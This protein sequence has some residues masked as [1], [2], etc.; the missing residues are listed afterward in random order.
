MLLLFWTP[1][2]ASGPDTAAEL[3]LV[4]SDIAQT[5]LFGSPVAGA[6]DVDGDGFDDLVVGVWAQ[7]N[8]CNGDG[9]AYLFHGSSEGIDPASEAKILSDDLDCGD[10]Y[11]WSVFG[12]VD[13]DQDGFDEVVVGAS[14]E[15]ADE[16]NAS[17]SAYVFHGAPEGLADP[18]K[19]MPQTSVSAGNFGKAIGGG[20]LNGD[21]FDDL[22]IGAVSHGAEGTVTGATYVYLGGPAGLDRGTETLLVPSDL[23]EDIDFGRAVVAEDVDGDGYADL[24]LGS[25]D[26]GWAEDAGAVYIYSGG[27]EGPSAASEWKLLA[28]DAVEEQRFGAAIAVGD[29]DADG[30]VELVVGAP[31]DDDDRG[32]V[33]VYAGTSSGPDTD[34]EEVLRLEDA[35]R[36]V[37]FGQSLAL[38]GDLGSDGFAD[39]VVGVHGDDTLGGMAGAIVVFDGS[40]SE[41]PLRI[42]ASDGAEGDHFGTVA[43]L[44]DANGDGLPDLAVGAPWDSTAKSDA[45]AVY[46]YPGACPD[47]DGDRSCDVDDCAPDDP[48]IFP[49]A[50]EVVADGIDQDCDGG[51][52]CLADAD[53]DGWG[54]EEVASADLDCEDA[55][56]SA[57]EGDCDDSDPS[58]H[59]DADEICNGVDDNCD[60]RTDDESAVDPATW[61]ADADADGYT[62]PE[63][64][65]DACQP[66]E[67]YAPA[68]VEDCDDDDP[69]VHPGADEIPGDGID[70]DCDGADEDTAD[71]DDPDDE[72]C[73]C[74]STAATGAWLLALALASARRRREQSGEL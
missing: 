21:G 15:D 30:H 5:D 44:G 26:D 48:E 40:S 24:L 25:R 9:S 73:G 4:P 47:A 36:Q 37:Y 32:A 17:G 41:A 58:V 51:D 3:E 53:G 34:S 60:G 10:R 28:S 49:G 67:G 22:A 65:T 74:G 14:T 12:G 29:L 20:D 45:G 19:L 38:P 64:S 35:V 59:P 23:S 69:A 55:G 72:G 50:T 13:L 11:G 62:D 2:A 31:G 68:G 56:E 61:Y 7:T 43:A 46:V 27:A 16:L 52:L 54:G 66:P 33:Y 57:S 71:P 63:A 70:Q 42:T 6:G 8:L 18:W 1:A 39:L